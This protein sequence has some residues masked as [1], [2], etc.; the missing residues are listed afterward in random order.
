[1]SLQGYQLR[2]FSKTYK[3]FQVGVK[4]GPYTKGLSIEN[5]C[6]SLEISLVFK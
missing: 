3:L 4:D 1:M 2:C 5:I 6:F